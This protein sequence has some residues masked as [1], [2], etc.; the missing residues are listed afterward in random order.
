MSES[1][2]HIGANSV[3][4]AVGK[5][6][7]EVGKEAMPE[8]VTLTL[9]RPLSQKELELMTEDIFRLKDQGVEVKVV[10]NYCDPIH[11]ECRF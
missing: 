5:K 6:M 10:E 9:M 8:K 1:I 4:G 11:V 2:K 7:L 3:V